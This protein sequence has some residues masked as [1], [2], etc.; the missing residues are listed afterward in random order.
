MKLYIII[1]KSFD[2]EMIT[3]GGL[4]R[5]LLFDTPNAIMRL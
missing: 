1:Y 2:L 5:I 4:V 3:Q